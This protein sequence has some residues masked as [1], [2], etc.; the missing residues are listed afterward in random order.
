MRYFFYLLIF[1]LSIFCSSKKNTQPPVPKKG[2]LDLVSWNF[3]TDG[4]VSL[5]GEWEF[6]YRK[7]ISPEDF[8]NL[9]ALPQKDFI[10][11]PSLW[12]SK[13]IDGVELS[14]EGFATYR[15]R[16][17]ANEY[18][19]PYGLR[20]NDMYSAYTLFLNGEIVAKNG[21]PG[22]TISDEKAEWYP[23]VSYVNLKKGE[24][25]FVLH[26]SNYAHRKGG[27]WSDFEI[28][29]SREISNYKNWLI[30]FDFFLIGSLLIMG[31]YHFG[32]F[33]LRRV[34]LSSLILSLFC[35]CTTFR[36]G[37]TSERLFVPYLPFRSFETQVTIE[38]LS[39]FLSF[40]LF[41]KFI[42]VLFT[43]IPRKFLDYFVFGFF[44]S[45]ILL[46]LTTKATVYSHIAVISQLVIILS[47]LYIFIFII[48]EII[49]KQEGA[50]AAFTGIAILFS[51]ALLDML[52]QNEIIIFSS[53]PPIFLFPFG[54][55]L[56]LFF[57][58]FLLSQR[59]SKAF[60]SVEE[61]STNLLE[62]NLAITKFVPSEF[63]LQLNKNSVTDI[64]LG[65]QMQRDMSVMF[66]DIREF[67][68]LSETMNPEDN[69]NFINA[70]LN[71]MN[72]CIQRNNGFIDKY[73][74]DAIMALFPKD[75]I[76]ALK[77]AIQ[78][79]LAVTDY[80]LEREKKN[81]KVIQVGFGIH[82]GGLMLGII[83]TSNRM[84]GTVISDSVN[85]AS[86]LEGLTKE[87]KVGIIVSENLIEQIED[88]NKFHFR[89][90]DRVQVKGKQNKVT[91]YHVYD[92]LSE[93]EIQSID[94]IKIDFESGVRAF[95]QG[96][97]KEA[98][99]L[100]EKILSNLKTDF[101]SQIYLKRC[102]EKLNKQETN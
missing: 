40:S 78:M 92:G 11:I 52:Y 15:L 33:A 17:F 81:Y 51:T 42:T 67:T 6:Y 12:N 5:H 21:I 79:R 13:K 68:N 38:Y 31:I 75:P 63:L 48:R 41:Y 22:K 70:Y 28:G 54:V 34:D 24:N 1:F 86:R 20:V 7:F 65:D 3:E 30:A 2:E 8:Q 99:F 77:A 53:I 60:Y 10:A 44:A 66:S 98:E 85:L 102:Q 89:L 4:K 29:T 36:I 37:L 96:K 45:M 61:L 71:R 39:F 19:K 90:L 26:I 95:H 55:F 69:F 93:A 101:P 83:G 62:T 94:S 43:N 35:V 100:F 76:D 9:E 25:E 23:I 87:Y 82:Y 32:L 91:V 97:F 18:S 50:L 46:V 14:N 72:P 73:I 49:K 16:V 74:G 64:K 80:N 56:F 27:T 47:A 59:F 58:S 88:K 84:D 57:Q